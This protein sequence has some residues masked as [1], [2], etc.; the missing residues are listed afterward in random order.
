[1]IYVVV[2]RAHVHLVLP[3][4]VCT[5]IFGIS[6]YTYIINIIDSMKGLKTRTDKT[7]SDCQSTYNFEFLR[8]SIEELPFYRVKR[9]ETRFSDFFNFEHLDIFC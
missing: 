9:N 5:K 4:P 3:I 8:D 1:M 6:T 2:S 7:R